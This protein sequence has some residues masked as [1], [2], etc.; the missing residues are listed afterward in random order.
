[1]RSSKLLIAGML[2]G[3][4]FCACQKESFLDQTDSTDLNKQVVFSDSTYT[5]DFLSGIYADIGFSTAP[6]RFGG[7]GLDASSDE[8]GGDQGNFQGFS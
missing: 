3:T 4:F 1:M 2:A 5:I 8:A 7:G 6:K